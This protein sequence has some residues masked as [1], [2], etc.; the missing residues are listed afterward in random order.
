MTRGDDHLNNAFRQ[1]NLLK[2]EDVLAGGVDRLQ[3]VHAVREARKRL[4]TSCAA[5]LAGALDW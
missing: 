5:G 1:A 2:W 3:Q 4:R